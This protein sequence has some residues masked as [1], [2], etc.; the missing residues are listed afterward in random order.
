MKK[1]LKTAASLLAAA[2]CLAAC[3]PPQSLINNAAPQDSAPA[4]TMPPPEMEP[5]PQNEA[6]VIIMLP[7]GMEAFARQLAGIA[8]EDGI[9]LRMVTKPAGAGYAAAVQDELDSGAAP[10]IYW[11]E[12]EADA[13]AVWANGGLSDIA[14][15]SESPSMAALAGTVPEKSR[16]VNSQMVYGLPLGYYAEGYLVNIELLAEFL[17]AEDEQALA[18]DLESCTQLQWE[19]M[20]DALQNYLQTP[21]RIQL[22][23]GN[24]TYTTPARRPADAKPMRGM[25]AVPERESEA[26]A[27]AALNAILNAAFPTYEDWALVEAAEKSDKLAEALPALLDVIDIETLYMGSED[28]AVWRG[29]DFPNRGKAGVYDAGEMLANGT[30]MFLRTDSRTAADIAKRHPQLKG[31]LAMVP[32]KLPLLRADEEGAQSAESE[33]EENAEALKIEKQIEENNT[34][35]AYASEGYL[36]L[37]AGSKNREWAESLIL[38]LYTTDEGRQIIEDG[39]GLLPFTSGFSHDV[40]N[41]QIWQAAVGEQGQYISMPQTGLARA[42]KS[43]GDFVSAELME[44]AE[45]DAALQRSFYSTCYAALGLPYQPPAV[46]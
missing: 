11:L 24:G 33:T 7:T 16:L 31:K 26:L 18:A 32:V 20:V 39:L 42:Q 21:N 40:L 38:R 15:E 43:I 28:G 17:G 22:K 8:K 35:L 3:G 12:G 5:A 1:A 13:L 9:T 19:Y 44:T 46:A 27:A 29:P 30:V 41:I 4:L 14:A 23:I 6:E 25:F 45:W 34:R 37:A 36:C 2:I 10:D